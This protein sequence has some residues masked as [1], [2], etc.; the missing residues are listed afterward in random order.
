MQGNVKLE[1]TKRRKYASVDLDLW[2]TDSDLSERG[3]EAVNE[4]LHA[5]SIEFLKSGGRPFAYLST[6]CSTCAFVPR[7]FPDQAEEVAAKIRE[8]LDTEGMTQPLR[9][10]A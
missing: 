2:A 9:A 8:I 4:V 3:L 10:A 1:V 6:S 7:L 5:A